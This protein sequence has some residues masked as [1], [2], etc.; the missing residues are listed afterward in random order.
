[1]KMVSAA[2]LRG[3]QDRLANS[4]VFAAGFDA[5]FNPV[6]PEGEDAP[7]PRETSSHLTIPITSDK[8]LC[9]GVNS[10]VAKL[11][12][13][14]VDA[15]QEAGK[16]SKI[17]IIGDKGRSQISRSHS[18]FIDTTIDETTKDPFN[19]AKACA[20]AERALAISDGVD[21]I[22]I[23]FNSFVSAIKYDT[24][25]RSAANFTSAV[26]DVAE[27]AELPAPLNQYE[28]EPELLEEALQ[29]MFEYGLALEIYCSFVDAAT[30]EQSSR[31]QAMD[32]ASKNSEEMV[33]KLT[34]IYNRAR[35]ARITTELIEIISGAESLKG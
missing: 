12:K 14:K 20:I 28:L 3:D 10:A 11:V 27:G 18:Q 7:A 29:N 25:S 6:V 24:M 13:L 2:K 17:M 5:I 21:S 26:A 9:G 19:F 16:D 1:M 4:K 32:N 22:D 30:A 8:G 23:V 31:M 35:Q 34:I 33:E 15:E